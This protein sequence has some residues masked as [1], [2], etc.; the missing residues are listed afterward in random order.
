MHDGL[1]S[2]LA[3]KPSLYID[4]QAAK[5]L[6]P[7]ISAPAG[8]SRESNTRKDAL[9]AK[10]PGPVYQQESVNSFFR[11]LLVASPAL[12]VELRKLSRDDQSETEKLKQIVR[13]D[14]WRVSRRFVFE[15]KNIRMHYF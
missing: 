14:D 15:R 7:E 6:S 1:P 9:Q 13:M 3:A 5:S 2:E 11:A 12:K 4:R 8:D 10:Q